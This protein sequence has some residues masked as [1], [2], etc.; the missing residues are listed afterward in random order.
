MRTTVLKP[1][2]GIPSRMQ[3]YS[4]IPFI[5]VV[6]VEDSLY[7][8]QCLLCVT[9]IFVFCHLLVFISIRVSSVTFLK[10]ID[11]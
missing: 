1:H 7:V 4:D 11:G 10:F 6:S 9:D 5:L 8:L 2:P 3:I